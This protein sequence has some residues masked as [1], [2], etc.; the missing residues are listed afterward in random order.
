MSSFKLM[1]KNI[2]YEKIEVSK[3]ELFDLLSIYH[4]IFYKIRGIL[5][6]LKFAW[7]RIYTVLAAQGLPL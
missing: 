7:N 3:F 5:F 6:G 4:K 1:K 2:I